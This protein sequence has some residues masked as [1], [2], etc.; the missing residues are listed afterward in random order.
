M[1]KNNTLACYMHLHALGNPLWA[2]AIV[3]L[4]QDYRAQ[5]KT[6]DVTVPRSKLEA[7]RIGIAL[8]ATPVNG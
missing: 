8:S 5:G 4:A 3:H 7:R 1:V 6:G 2:E